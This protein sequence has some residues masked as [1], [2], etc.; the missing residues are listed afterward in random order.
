M[1]YSFNWIVLFIVV[2][3]AICI[4]ISTQAQVQSNTIP[5]EFIERINGTDDPLLI[6]ESSLFYITELLTFC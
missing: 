6:S 2:V 3:V 5:D 4:S 1:K